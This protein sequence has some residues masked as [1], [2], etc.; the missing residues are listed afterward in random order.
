MH[1][2]CEHYM[3][4]IVPLPYPYNALE[5][6]I[7][8]KTMRIHHDKHLQAYVDNLNKAIKDYPQLHGMSVTQLL[9]NCGRISGCVRKEVYNN[10]GGVF[11]HTFYFE[12]MSPP[13]CDRCPEGSLSEMINRTYGG[14]EHF[15][16]K[17]CNAAMSV[18][19]SGYAWLVSDR[20][21]CLQIVTT[22]NQD[23]PLSQC[24]VPILNID[25]WEHS[26]YLKHYNKRIDYIKDWF[27]V[28]NWGMAEERYKCMKSC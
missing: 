23:S 13:C 8:E 2:F 1:E 28:V 7:D 18:F 14:F 21:K 16:E 22:A 11:N 9:Q 3:F 6:Y 24:L 25:V 10:A 20:N 26:Y 17:F 4:E 5:P 15:K 12:G 19:G 27:N